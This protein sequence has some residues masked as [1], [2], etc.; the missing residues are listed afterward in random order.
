MKDIIENFED[1]AESQ[2]YNMLQSNGKLKCFCGRVFDPDEEGG[3]ISPNPYAMPVCG[4]CLE[5]FKQQLKTKHE[6]D[7]NDELPGDWF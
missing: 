5:H 3:T 7:F 4:E 6:K 1:A 2:Y